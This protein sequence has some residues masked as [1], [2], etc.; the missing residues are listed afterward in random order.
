MTAKRDFKKRVRRRQAETGESYTAAR[1]QVLGERPAAATAEPQQQQPGPGAVPVVEMI[2]VTEAAEAVGLK[3]WVTMAAPLTRR[4]GVT[5]T[6]V[7]L[8]DALLATLDDPALALLRR[9]VLQGERPYEPSPPIVSYHE[10]ARFAIRIK[11][12]IGGISETGRMLALTV[13]DQIVVAALAPISQVR[14]RPDGRPHVT[15]TV[16]DDMLGGIVT[17]LPY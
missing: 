13:R 3:C 11:A 5:T 6:L 10:L 9:A 14:P 12:G 1:A 4:L 8:R 17:V 16:P 7:K 15:I 2:D